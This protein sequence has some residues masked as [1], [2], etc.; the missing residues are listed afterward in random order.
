MGR[1]ASISSSL[2]ICSLTLLS[3]PGV[4]LLR[5]LAVVFA[6]PWLGKGGRRGP[7][8]VNPGGGN[9]PPRDHQKHQG[10]RGNHKS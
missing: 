7:E 5:V 4:G 10:C 8:E 9:K 2:L 3:L 1:K 6:K